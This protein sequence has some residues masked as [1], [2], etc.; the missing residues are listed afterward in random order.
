MSKDFQLAWNCPHVIGEEKVTLGLDR[1]TLVTSKPIGGVGML[2]LV[3]NDTI[4][5]PQVNGVQS[6][7]ILKGSKK[8]PFRI[9]PGE[10]DLSVTTGGQ[11][12]SIVLPTGYLTADRVLALLHSG[13]SALPG[14][15]SLTGTKD[16]GY[17]VFRENLELGPYSKI[18][19]QGGAK[20]ALGFGSQVGTTGRLVLPPWTLVGRELVDP[21][22]DPTAQSRGYY[23]RFLN[24]I[25]AGYYFRV[26][27][28]VAP[29]LCLRCLGTE[30]ENDYRFDASNNPLLVEDNNLLYQSCL[31][32]LL[33]EIR[34]NIYYPWYGTNLI[35]SIG[36]KALSGSVL[37]IQQTIRT[38]LTNFQNLQT[39]QAKFQRLTAK[40]RLYAVDRV[41]VT[42][43]AN[44]PTTF[45]VEVAVRSYSN[46]PVEITIVYSTPGAFALPGTN[47]LSLGNFG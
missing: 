16:Q 31:K 21:P 19:I 7:A 46:D 2:K 11:T 36:T 3:A 27:Y 40:E 9:L 1:Q 35:G 4:Q 43:S 15:T 42:P 32:V 33:T 44:D 24:P 14:R 22:I 13:F 39:T 25:R 30:V 6:S 37:A 17:L 5:V 23:I 18:L 38:A 28:P 47:N 26:T 29:D 12:L 45:L 8:E 41:S 20:S 34:S 10:Q